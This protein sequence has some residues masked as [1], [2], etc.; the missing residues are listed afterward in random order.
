MHSEKIISVGIIGGG[1][2]GKSIFNHILKFPFKVVWVNTLHCDDEQM[3]FKKKTNRLLSNK[4]INQKEFDS[5]FNRITIADSINSVKDCTIVIECIT[6]DL[7]IKNKLFN[8]LKNII[9]EDAILVSNSSSIFPETLKLSDTLKR[10]FSGFHFFY[11]VE[12]NRLLEIIPSHQITQKNI[13]FLMAFAHTIN[14]KP[15]LQNEVNAFAVN[16]FF[17]EIQSEVFNYCQSNNVP[18]EAA[19]QV[20]KTHLFDAGVFATMDYIGFDILYYA[21]NNYLKWHDDPQ[22]IEPLLKFLKLKIGQGE[23]GLKVQHGFLKYPLQDVVL[24][25]K[26]SS[27]ILNF[28]TCIF[29]KF[30]NKYTENKI[31]TKEEIKFVVAEYTNSDYNPFLIK[32]IN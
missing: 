13:D 19:D 26:D 27:E 11:P 23:T 17:L 12:T 24:S 18:F 31:F 30:A 8:D 2:M 20:I 6:E 21:I 32:K 10:R 9:N 29:F 3:K 16:R 7:E 4:I 5:F 15:M 1:K 25:D 14:K 28:I 22:Q